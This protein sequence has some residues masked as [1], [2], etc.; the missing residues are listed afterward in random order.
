M[1]IRVLTSARIFIWTSGLEM[2][3][4]NL[5]GRSWAVHTGRISQEQEE[6]ELGDYNTTGR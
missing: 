4:G 5:A 1:D 2:Q 3:P 6:Q